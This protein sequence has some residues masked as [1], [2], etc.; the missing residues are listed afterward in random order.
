MKA[1][2]K[3]MTVISV[4]ATLA[5]IFVVA[6]PT[7]LGYG[8]DTLFW[9][10]WGKVARG[11]HVQVSVDLE[12][13]D[14]DSISRTLDI[15]H[16]AVSEST[17]PE[18]GSNTAAMPAADKGEGKVRLL[19]AN[20][21]RL[22][23]L[24]LD[25]SVNEN[26]PEGSTEIYFAVEAPEKQFVD[27]EVHL[28]VTARE[29]ETPRVQTQI[30]AKSRS[31]KSLDMKENINADWGSQIALPP[32]KLSDGSQV[33]EPTPDIRSLFPVISAPADTGEPEGTAP[34]TSAPESEVPEDTGDAGDPESAAAAG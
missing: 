30:I 18:D 11:D 24:T 2:G 32:A 20:G 10:L 3:V 21:S 19:S 12:Y 34:E 5:A 31:P 23:H 15:S 22:W 17:F 4:I 27:V 1:F 29:G 8:V 26:L 28:R 14:A 16:I 33:I 9:D 6:C 7:L 13:V 25:P